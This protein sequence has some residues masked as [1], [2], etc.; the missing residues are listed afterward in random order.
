MGTIDARNG[1]TPANLEALFPDQFN[2][3]TWNL[4]AIS[5]ITRSYSIGVGD[6]NVHLYSKKFAGWAQDDWQ[7]S[8]RLTLNLGLRYDLEMGVFAND[9]SVPPFQEAG[10]PNDY[11]N[12]QPRV[13][14][15][16]RLSEQTVV[17][18]GTGLYYGDA[19]GADQ[20][21]ATGNAQLVVINYPND[22]RPDFAAN[23]TNGR[24]LPT[25]DEAIRRF[26]YSNNN[27]PGCLIRDLQEFVA[28]PPYVH[29]PRTF[30]TSIG[31][32]RQFGNTIAVEAD[33]LYSK[34][35]HEK[36]VVD[37]INLTFNPATGANLPFATRA[38]RPYPD[39][40]VVSMNGHL[41]R[42]AYHALQSG[43]TKRFSHHWQAA[44][45]YTLSGLWNADTKP[46]SGLTP[47]DFPT[48]P[49]LGGEWAFSADDQRHRAVFNGI[50]Q[51]A[52]GFQVSG[53]HYL[54]AGIRQGNSY[55]GDLRATGATFSARLRPDGTIVPRNSLIAPP[56]NRT[57]LRLQQRIPLH[58]RA[59]I[60]GIAEVFNMFNRPNWGIG[61]VENNPQYLQHV[62]A[63]TR[64]LQFGFRVTF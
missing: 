3:D 8:D 1:P 48:V 13:G 53:L 46:F 56:Q 34:G 29:L 44:A 30:Q 26:C 40:G 16:Y 57:D 37:N 63:Q 31:F 61:I 62:S 17:R 43:F 2:A 49:D 45:T 25:Y 54:G 51:V 12:I 24:P 36:D 52:H 42:S 38:T 6:F 19:I 47:V 15:A 50:W 11:K 10:R 28:Q 4:A 14:F 18:G 39:W 21:F 64:T 7:L 5:S 59:A 55:G 32:Q 60:D 41:A 9:V 23:P 35:T 27:A 33:Y 58:G 20:S 22:G